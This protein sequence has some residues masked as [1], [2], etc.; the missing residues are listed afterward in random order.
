MGSSGRRSPWRR[1]Y[2]ASRGYLPTWIARLARQPPKS[3]VPRDSARRSL[4]L[5]SR[6]R[7]PSRGS[8]RAEKR[9]S[10]CLYTNVGVSSP[11]RPPGP[12]GDS[13][14]RGVRRTPLIQAAPRRVRREPR[15]VG[16]RAPA[17][18][19][20]PH[21]GGGRAPRGRG[22]PRAATGETGAKVGRGWRGG[23][24]PTATGYVVH[25]KQRGHWTP[26]QRAMSMNCSPPMTLLVK[27][28]ATEPRLRTAGMRLARGRPSRMRS[29]P[30]TIW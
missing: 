16:T 27:R 5:A 30:K 12:L 11:R 26:A 18:T 10:R 9:S 20:V 23:V 1:S 7:G 2:S 29:R 3:S 25:F 19:G 17:G 24:P 22:R 13:R 15:P 8:L 4:G 14:G 21:C 6:P 28:M